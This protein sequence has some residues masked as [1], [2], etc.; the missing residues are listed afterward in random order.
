MLNNHN[1]CAFYHIF[2]ENREV[3]LH[4]S[5]VGQVRRYYSQPVKTRK[6]LFHRHLKISP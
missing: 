5:V 2:R 3:T 4:Y 1:N 6:P